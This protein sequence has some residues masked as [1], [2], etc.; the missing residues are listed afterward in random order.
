VAERATSI[1]DPADERVAAVRRFNRIYTRRIGALDEGHL[2]TSFSLAEARVLY[3]LAQRDAPTAA[4]LGRELQLDA[5]YLSRLLRGFERAGLVERSPSPSDARQSHLRL[6]AAGRETAADLEA[7]ARDAI[8]GLLA[9]LGDGDQRRLLGAVR[10]LEEL[11]APRRPDRSAEPYLLRS[12]RPGDLGW[13]VARN[14]ALYAAEYGW[15]ARYEGLVARIVADFVDRFDPRR[16]RCWIAERDGENVGS[17]FLV[18]HPEREGVAKLRLLIVEPSARGLG[19]GRRLVDECTRFA[20]QSGY[21]TITLWTQSILTAARHIYAAAGYR[22][23]AEEP[24]TSFGHELV[25]ETWEL[26]L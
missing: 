23:V 11:L 9:T 25:A 2:H 4:E 12:P 21:H 8:A 5:G 14:G 19:I 22:R 16:E 13:V 15:D 6:T 18:R 7:R 20:R 17:V 24:H 10:T 1:S 3:E 26:V